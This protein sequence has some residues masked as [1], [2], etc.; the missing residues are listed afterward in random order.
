MCGLGQKEV[1]LEQRYGFETEV[2][3]FETCGFVTQGQR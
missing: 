3:G 1:V 2:L